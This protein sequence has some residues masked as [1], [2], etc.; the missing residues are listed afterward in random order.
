MIWKYLEALEKEIKVRYQ[1]EKIKT[2]YIG[3]GTPSSL[4]IKQLE[5]LFTILKIFSFSHNYEFTFE[6]N[7][8]ISYEKLDLLKIN[9]VNRISIGVESTNNKLLKDLG[10]KYSFQLI[11]DKIKYIKKIG[12]K[13]INVDLI[14]ALKNQTILDLK[15]DLKNILSLNISHIS[16]YSLMIEPH[17]I[18]YIQKRKEIDSEID[19]QMYQLICKTLKENG[20]I[21]YEISNF[22]KPNY[23]SKHNLVYWN[24]ENYYGFGISSAS[25]INNIR[26]KNTTSLQEYSKGLYI[27]E[28]EILS[29]KDIL[30]YALILGFR[31]INGLNKQEFY[32]KYKVNLI[33]L[34]NIKELLKKKDLIEDSENIYINYNKIYIENSILI[35]FV[36][37]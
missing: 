30:S 2:I 4:N 26:Y 27:K 16:T 11:K 19:F 10:R 7:P 36:G 9:K 17:T 1:G 32:N 23:E 12:I 13:N 15:K 25:Y 8:D 28:K 6:V 22:S 35:N 37:E 5:K 29:K 14:Y 33:D 18:F 24:N 21:H 3:G 20:Y 31:K 34:Y